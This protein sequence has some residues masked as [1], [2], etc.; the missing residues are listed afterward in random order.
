MGL[1]LT[2]NPS[3]KQRF[4]D[5]FQNRKLPVIKKMNAS[6]LLGNIAHS[7]K[8]ACKNVYI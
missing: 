3:S 2:V 5:E 1:T 4:S 6:E 8:W 7:G